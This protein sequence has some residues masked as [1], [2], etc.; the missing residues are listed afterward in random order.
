MKRLQATVRCCD[1]NDVPHD[2]CNLKIFRRI[3]TS[4]PDLSQSWTVVLWDD[5]AD[6]NRNIDPHLF[7][8]V[9]NV[10]N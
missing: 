8:M 5:A 1:V 4:D 7:Q 10:G 9:E 3:D 2:F 6:D